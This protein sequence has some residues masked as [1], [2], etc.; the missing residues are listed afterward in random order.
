MASWATRRLVSNFQDVQAFVVA[1]LKDEL[2]FA[3]D[4]FVHLQC[5]AARGCWSRGARR[6]SR[7]GVRSLFVS[8]FRSVD[9]GYPSG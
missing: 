4:E 3:V 5:P 9:G 2:R 1:H 8:P 6:G 7:D